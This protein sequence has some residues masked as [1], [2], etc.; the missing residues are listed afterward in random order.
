MAALPDHLIG[1][2]NVAAA[3]VTEAAWRDGDQWLAAVLAH[4]D[5]NRHLLAAL[6]AEHLPDVR[7]RVPDATYLAWL[8]CSALG[9]GDAPFE[10][11][12]QRGV[13]LSPGPDFGSAGTGH[14]RL[15]FAT[16]RG[17][18]DRRSSNADGRR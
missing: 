5:R 8:D 3:E 14:V 1:S 17:D 13:Q 16:V 18:P 2:I 12:R 7:Y 6:L 10:R 4:L 15:N 11:F 9:D